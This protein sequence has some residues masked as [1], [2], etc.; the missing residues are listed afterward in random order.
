MSL[1]IFYFSKTITHSHN[2]NIQHKYGLLT[3][4]FT[5]QKLDSENR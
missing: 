5:V 3:T 1:T 4:T 2:L